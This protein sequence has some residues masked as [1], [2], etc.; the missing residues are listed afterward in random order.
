[1]KLEEGRL[2]ANEVVELLKP[3]CEKIEI[4]GSIRREKPEVKDIDIVLLPK[5]VEA[6]VFRQRLE[7]AGAKTTLAGE[8]FLQFLFKEAQIDVYLAKDGNFEILL[9]IRTGSAEHNRMLCSKAL[10][11]GMKMNFILGLIDANKNVVENT[12]RGILE[13]LLGRYVEPKERSL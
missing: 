5:G 12:E 7:E 4:A 6:N 1:M 2:I 10:Q 9:L 8:K 13:K 3:L 11:K